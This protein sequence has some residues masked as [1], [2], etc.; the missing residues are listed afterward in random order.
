MLIY[1]L[2]FLFSRSR[3]HPLSELTRQITSP[4][5]NGHAPP[6]NKIKKELSICQSLLCPDLVSFPV[7]SQ[8]E[9]AGST[10]G[11]AVPSILLSFSLATIL[12]PEPEYLIISSKVLKLMVGSILQSGFKV[13]SFESFVGIIYGQDYDGI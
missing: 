8:I 9:A 3:S 6:F 7:L 1:V 12:P 5:W 2:I 13:D 10:P 4:I 11:G